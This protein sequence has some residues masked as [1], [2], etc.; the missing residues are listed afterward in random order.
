MPPSCHAPCTRSAHRCVTA[1]R[2]LQPSGGP[3]RAILH[4]RLLTTPS[5]ENNN[6]LQVG[7]TAGGS[8]RGLGTESDWSRRR[9]RARE[10]IEPQGAVPPPR[11][12]VSH[13]A[14][15]QHEGSA[16]QPR[17]CFLTK[18]RQLKRRG[19]NEDLG[20]DSAGQIRGAGGR[21]YSGY[22]G[23]GAERRATGLL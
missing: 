12:R 21:V 15:R 8:L 2:R 14:N 5:N 19:R 20:G 22:R 3:I 4:S 23:W 1:S 16:T 13:L 10:R 18:W 7:N 6:P 11:G 9:T 17:V